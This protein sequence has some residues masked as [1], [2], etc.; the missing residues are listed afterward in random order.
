[1]IDWS[2][3]CPFILIHFIEATAE[4]KVGLMDHGRK[5][6]ELCMHLHRSQIIFTWHINRQFLSK[7][8]MMPNR[9]IHEISSPPEEN[10]FQ[11]L[12]WFKWRSR[13]RTKWLQVDLHFTFSFQSL[14]LHSL[15][16]LPGTRE[17]RLEW[18]G[19]SKLIPPD[20]VSHG[21]R[22]PE[23]SESCVYTRIF[24]EKIRKYHF[25]LEPGVHKPTHKN[26]SGWVRLGKK[27][28][29]NVCECMLVQKQNLQN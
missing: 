22:C 25:F 3:A 23:E 12:S 10:L 27:A 26:V 24:L 18:W 28:F 17:P 5:L 8:P 16:A 15:L 14:Q 6:K 21:V 29:W 4:V 7:L 1:M 20:Q 13:S 11:I 9:V 19:D 2:L